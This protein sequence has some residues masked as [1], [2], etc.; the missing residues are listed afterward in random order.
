MKASLLQCEAWRGS[1]QSTTAVP[2]SQ[3]AFTHWA[4]CHHSHVTSCLSDTTP[5][6][7]TTALA[8]IELSGIMNNS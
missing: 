4:A 8:T 5:A 1:R 2:R 7:A 6:D 3:H